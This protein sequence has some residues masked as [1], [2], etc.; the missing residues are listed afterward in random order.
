[1]SDGRPDRMAAAEREMATGGDRLTAGATA[2][3]ALSPAEL[4]MLADD[5]PDAAG[6]AAEERMALRDE[7]FAGFME[8]LFGDGPEP[9]AV[10]VRI[11]GIMGSLAAETA[12]R[13]HGPEEWSDAAAVGRVLRRHESR[14]ATDGARGR[15]KLSVWLWELAAEDDQECVSSTILHLLGLLVSEGTL[16]RSAVA[17]AFALAKALRP[18][19]IGDMSLADIAVLCGDG[20]RATPS[21][22]GKRL[23]NARLAGGGA[24]GSSAPYQK[25]EGTVRKYRDAQQGN[26]NRRV[27]RHSKLSGRKRRKK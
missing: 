3:H 20:G 4:A 17:M 19:L 5:A 24:K 1:M 11:A 16:W 27:S 9:G 23:Y 7:V 26:K 18:Q 12:E 22:R 10:R 15:A 21:A 13:M 6:S 25:R 8:Y 14:L 2:L